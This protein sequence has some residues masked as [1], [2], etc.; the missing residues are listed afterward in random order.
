[1]PVLALVLVLVL[2][3]RGI[4]PWREGAEGSYLYGSDQ[5]RRSVHYE[6]SLYK[7]SSHLALCL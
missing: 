6:Y 1:M 3:E 2:E 7:T 4:S 5:V